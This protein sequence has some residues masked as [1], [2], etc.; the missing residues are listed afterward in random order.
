MK[1][2]L[3]FAA[4]AALLVSCTQELELSITSDATS[5]QCG[6]EGGSFDAVV[7]T[8]GSW[9]AT[10]DDP[11]VTFTPE[12][13]DYS[14]PIHIEVGRND[15]HYT[16]VI[17]IQLTSNLSTSSRSSKI[18]ITQA[19][20]PFIL[21]E[22]SVLRV[23]PEGGPARFQ[24]NASASWKVAATTLDGASTSALTVTP[25]THG[26]NS[27]EVTVMVPAYAEPVIRR[28]EITLA[29]EDSPSTTAVLT[30]EQWPL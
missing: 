24:V 4:F 10:C 12:S 1:K 14:F 18:V 27:V 6:P 20:A 17:P 11:A 2:I 29:L 25:L 30:V 16:K 19:C 28:W 23:G 9:T 3:I 7:F 15:E 26:P 8:N 21:C 22:R 13:G 5:Y